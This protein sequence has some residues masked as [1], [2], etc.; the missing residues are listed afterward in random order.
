[1]KVACGGRFHEEG[2][3]NPYREVWC[4]DVASVAFSLARLFRS[5]VG[6]YACQGI[7]ADRIADAKHP[8]HLTRGY[9]FQRPGALLA[10]SCCRRYPKQVNLNLRASD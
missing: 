4:L 3:Q 6:G 10:M 8:L 9:E 2:R 1:M 7:K 5:V